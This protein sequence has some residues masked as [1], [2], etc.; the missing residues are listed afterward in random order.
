MAPES[1]AITCRH[2][3]E[4]F[5]ECHACGLAGGEQADPDDLCAT[6]RALFCSREDAEKSLILEGV[7]GYNAQASTLGG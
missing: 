5:A 3:A 6:G 4:H 1:F 2:I 7:N